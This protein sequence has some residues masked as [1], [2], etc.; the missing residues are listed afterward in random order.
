MCF[1]RHVAVLLM[2]ISVSRCQ[3]SIKSFDHI[4]IVGIC[5]ATLLYPLFRFFVSLTIVSRFYLLVNWTWNQSRNSYSR[6]RRAL[7][8]AQRYDLSTSL[9]QTS[10]VGICL[11]LRFQFISIPF[12]CCLSISTRLVVYLLFRS[13]SFYVPFLH[14]D[15]LYSFSILSRSIVYPQNA[16][17]STFRFKEGRSVTTLGFTSGLVRVA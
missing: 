15:L 13:S 9:N 3:L 7:C 16:S 12:P 4:S 14:F 1:V 11:D 2:D 6:H 5:L 8:W 17:P 10:V